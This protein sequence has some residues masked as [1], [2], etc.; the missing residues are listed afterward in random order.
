MATILS[1]QNVTN[2]FDIP[3]T[4][5]VAEKK[6]NYRTTM[7]D[8]TIE[9]LAGAIKREGQL[10]PVRVQKRPDGK[11]DLVYGFRRY[12]AF[13]RLAAEKPEVYTTIRAEVSDEETPVVVRKIANLAENL[14]R[15]DL[16]TYDQAVAFLDL[17]NAEDMTGTRIANS[18]GKSVSYV[19][20]LVRIIE[21]LDDSVLTRWKAE[22][23]PN[24]GYDKEGK[25]LPNQHAV[26]TM[27]W[28]GKLVAKTPKAQQN[29]E[30][31]VAL[32]LRDPDEDENG[33]EGEGNGPRSIGSPKRATMVNLT[34]ALEAAEQKMKEAKADEKPE[35]KG[36]VSALKFAMGKVKSI[37]GVYT[38]PNPNDKDDE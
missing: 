26:C 34:K 19:N 14:A 13:K 28:L 25:K 12:A 35:L 3:L 22:C 15:E 23:H 36:I 24:F 4:A 27:D 29:Y 30:L 37:K 31:E 5:I 8:D 9:D 11:F 17:K 33:D 32:G 21:G 1:L 10:T 18:I 38:T 16:T 7:D 20:N 6:M 2:V